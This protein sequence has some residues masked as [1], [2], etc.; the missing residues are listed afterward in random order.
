MT[1]EQG[2]LRVAVADDDPAILEFVRD[3]L[4]GMGHVVT[5]SCATGQELIDACASN[6]PDLVV[7]DVK[8]PGID[9]I[10]A[11]ATI[12][13]RRATP[14]ILVTSFGE[15]D[16]ISRAL[17]TSVLAYLIKPIKQI[18]LEVAIAVAMRRFREHRAICDEAAAL[19]QTLEERK[20]IERAKG[21]LMRRG[22][23]GEEEAYKRLQKISTENSRRLH[24]TARM[25]ISIDREFRGDP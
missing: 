5:A 14:A 24:E 12:N 20:Q 17:R 11:A 19:R 2:G 21:V 8:M 9:G 25:V 22:R 3:V 15:T 16:L 10:E 4:E 7:T 13:R 23:L 1:P 18:D 6:P